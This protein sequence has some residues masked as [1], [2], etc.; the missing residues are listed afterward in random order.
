VM[1]LFCCPDVGPSLYLAA[2]FATC[3]PPYAK[4]KNINV[5]ANSAHAA[6]SSFLHLLDMRPVR[7]ERL[8][9]GWLSSLG[10]P[11]GFGASW[12]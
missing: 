7:F 11:E 10:R 1:L 12:W 3:V 5:P 2:V 6:T 4:N 8:V 9:C